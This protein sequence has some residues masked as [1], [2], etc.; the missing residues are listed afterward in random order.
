[1]GPPSYMRSVV[2]QNVVMRCMIVYHSGL[3]VPL[4]CGQLWHVAALQSG[5]I[6]G[7]C[8]FSSIIQTSYSVLNHVPYSLSLSI[9]IYIYISSHLH[10]LHAILCKRS[11]PP[12]VLYQ[13][14]SERTGLMDAVYD[15]VKPVGQCQQQRPQFVLWFYSV[16][17][18]SVN[19]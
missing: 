2:D 13:T 1:M 17:H 6:H 15:I 12:H 4:K 9:Y 7:I 8:C 16:F 10:C 3:P 18:H 19:N 14:A 11:V 5:K